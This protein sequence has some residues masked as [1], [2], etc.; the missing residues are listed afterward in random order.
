MESDSRPLVC[1]GL[2]IVRVAGGSRRIGSGYCGLRALGDHYRYMDRPVSP[3][4][5][6]VG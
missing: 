4:A 1:P 5:G 3:R 2:W 6:L